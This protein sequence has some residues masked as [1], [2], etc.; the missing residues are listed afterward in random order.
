MDKKNNKPIYK[1]LVISGGSVRAISHVGALHCLI[2]KGYIDLKQLKSIAGTSAGA[3]FG[4][5]LTI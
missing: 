3:L 1:H 2:E 5:L 4:C